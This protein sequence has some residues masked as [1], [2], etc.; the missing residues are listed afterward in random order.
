MKGIYKIC[1][2]T[3]GKVYIGQSVD[4]NAR[5]T[6][7][8][9]MLKGGKHYNNHL[10]M[11]YNKHGESKFE[12]SV[13]EECEDLDTQEIYWIS[14]YKSDKR[15]FGY[16]GSS[17]GVAFT[18]NAVV[19]AKISEKMLI[20]YNENP[21]T[22]KK[23]SIKSKGENNPFYNKKH[24]K[25]SIIKFSKWHIGIKQSEVTKEKRRK[26]MLE[27]SPNK[28]IKFSDEWKK[29]LSDSHKGNVA[30][31]K[32]TFS[33]EETDTI[34]KLSLSG[35]DSNEIASEYNCGNTRI[36][37][38]LKENN[39][40]L[41]TASRKKQTLFKNNIEKIK[42]MQQDGMTFTQIGECFSMHRRTIAKYLKQL[43]S[44]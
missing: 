36:I 24:T 15:E 42:K 35:K 8:K 10:T 29:K 13:I 30:Q 32:I 22:L 40:K 38:V 18:M 4:I 12:F 11:A 3:N 37:K 14:Y 43:E 25:E 39:I 21:D 20:F 2:L 33:K 6:K 34:I 28:G 26:W 44:L 9:L 1:N 23:M 41:N 27:N 19:K 5:L 31:N 7:H 16:N 17:G